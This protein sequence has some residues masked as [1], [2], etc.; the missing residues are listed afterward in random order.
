[1]KTIQTLIIVI[2]AIFSQP[3]ISQTHFPAAFDIVSDTF[4]TITLPAR[5]WQYAEDRAD[6]WTIDSIRQQAIEAKFRGIT[7]KKSEN[8]DPMYN[9][10][11]RFRLKNTMQRE[12]QIALEF[13][14]PWQSDIYIFDPTQKER[15]FRS[16]IIPWSKRDG[17]TTKNLAKSYLPVSIAA[18]DEWVVYM[19]NSTINGQG[20][21]PSGLLIQL[22][23]MDK[24]R[25]ELSQSEDI[26][27]ILTIKNSLFFGILLWVAI[28]NLF[29]FLI[30]KER[31]YLYF[32]LYVFFLGMTRFLT[33]LYHLFFREHPTILFPYFSTFSLAFIPFFTTHFFAICSEHIFTTLFWI[34][35]Y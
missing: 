20:T 16:G 3:G 35:C 26:N 5:H 17:Y 18:G 10:W 7:A 27:Y 12:A 4:G 24:M 30:V 23:D 34:S 22:Y 14:S 21:M 11:V 8:M 13:S 2:C 15:H 28:F 9:Y 29:F 33:P 32:A 25:S 31:V 19:K 1:M 6:S